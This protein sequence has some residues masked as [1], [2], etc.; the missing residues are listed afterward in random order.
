MT[1]IKLTK[2]FYKIFDLICDFY[3]FIGV[4]QRKFG[5]FALGEAIHTPTDFSYLLFT[6]KQA[7]S[8]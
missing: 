4:N 6:H 5:Y 7:F 3:S 8:C 2:E 1:F